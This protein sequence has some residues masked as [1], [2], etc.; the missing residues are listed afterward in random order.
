MS[1]SNFTYIERD[2]QFGDCNPGSDFDPSV[3]QYYSDTCAIQS[4]KLILDNF[5]IHK[6]AEELIE[7]AKLHG[8]Y[9]EGYGTPTEDVGKLL[10]L[11]GVENHASFNNNIF[12][13]ANEL[14]QHK[15]V[16]VSVDSNELWNRDGVIGDMK[17]W[18]CG[19]SPDHALIV[20]G[21]DTSDPDHVKVVL[22]DPGTGQLRVTYTEE[23]FVSAWKDSN[24]FMTSTNLAPEEYLG[25]DYTPEEH[26]A[27]I[28]TAQLGTL[29]DADLDMDTIAT[30]VGEAAKGAVALA[31]LIKS[32]SVL[33]ESIEGLQA[34]A[35]IPDVNFDL[36]TLEIGGASDTNFL[37]D[38]DDNSSDHFADYV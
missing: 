25:L 31:A 9:S 13:L 6:T 30:I 26:F 8:W 14:A 7:D 22:T 32:I 28:D 16:I 19:E 38:M 36:E 24:C 5:G 27:G 10:E 2:P 29:G 15:Q 20:A 11:Y 17:D 34:S 37:Q 3:Y 18:F 35:E 33:T 23:E 1:T 12:S 4:Q 21:L